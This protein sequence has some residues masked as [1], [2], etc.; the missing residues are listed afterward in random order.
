M[1][2]DPGYWTSGLQPTITLPGQVRAIATNLMAYFDLFVRTQGG[3]L[4]IVALLASMS[5]SRSSRS[6][7]ID[8]EL[9]LIMWALVALG[10]YS[11]V[12]VADRYIA[13]FTVLFWSGLL[14]LITLPNQ[15]QY[16]RLVATGAALLVAF[17]W[18]NIGAMNLE[19]LA[20]VTGFTPLSES[21]VPQNQFSDGHETDHRA[22]AEGVL[23][24]GLERGDKIGF[25]GYS[26][27]AYWARLARLNIVAEI[28]PEDLAAFWDANTQKQEEV[29]RAFAA[30]GV[31]AVV[32][33]PLPSRPIPV[34][35][36]VV[37][38]TGYLL[39]KI[40]WDN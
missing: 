38:P 21:G 29:L 37:G 1:A 22:V 9:V 28:Y 18:I 30:A 35:W 20:G 2:F 5:L 36:E 27:T 6:R 15:H 40:H 17:V 4:A 13:P 8:L 11:L 33:E 16:R 34:G 12:Y 26:F 14:G 32:A 39:Y 25:I 19:G 23:A 7:S 3:F 31:T 24:Q 10:M